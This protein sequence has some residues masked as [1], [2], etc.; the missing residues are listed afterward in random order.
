M[1]LPDKATGRGAGGLGYRGELGVLPGDQV[2]KALKL[3]EGA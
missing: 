3:T 2:S 1:R